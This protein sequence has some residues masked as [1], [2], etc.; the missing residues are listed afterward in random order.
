MKIQIAN[1]DI[2]SCY[3]PHEV[4]QLAATA[5]VDQEY[6]SGVVAEEASTKALQFHQVVIRASIEKSEQVSSD[7]FVANG[8]I[9]IRSEYEYD[10]FDFEKYHITINIEVSVEHLSCIEEHV[11]RGMSI[12]LTRSDFESKWKVR[13]IRAG[14]SF[15]RT[16]DK[17]KRD[18]FVRQTTLGIC[19]GDTGYL[20]TFA[21]ETFESEAV[22]LLPMGKLLTISKKY[23]DLFSHLRY[24]IPKSF[25]GISLSE[26]VNLYAHKIKHLPKDEAKRAIHAYN[27]FYV[28][29]DM[30]EIYRLG[31]QEYL[32]WTS[33]PEN[34]QAG[35]WLMQY[36]LRDYLTY[37]ELLKE[38][39]SP[40][41][42]AFLFRL[43]IISETLQYGRTVRSREKILGHPVEADLVNPKPKT[44]WIYPL[45]FSATAQAFRF[46]FFCGLTIS[47]FFA[48][49][50]WLSL[51]VDPSALIAGM[52][53]IYY[54]YSSK[55]LAPP[56]SEEEQP[57]GLYLK[58]TM[59]CH[60]AGPESAGD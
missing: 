26:D 58:M 27:W 22:R 28:A 41:L 24:F 29:P 34:F 32:S 47:V 42:G 60:E 9:E 59:L 13:C 18:Y 40:S 16:H 56:A 55:S 49:N 6:L 17:Q 20:Q 4:R 51:G 35:N 12:L 7:E 33:H 8:D 10:L 46:I 11:S 37:C 25:N 3:S 19:I 48:L 1:A 53:G 52:V 36:E 30:T 39:Y 50:T 2:D 45:I 57:E 14:D 5:V 44:R 15:W 43:G 38:I 54:W 21:L 23:R 31:E